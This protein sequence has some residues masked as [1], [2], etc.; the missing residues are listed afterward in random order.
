MTQISL[1]SDLIEITAEIN[2]F[3]Q[4]AGQAVIEIGKRLKHVRDNDLV[5]G[6]WEAWL[7]SLDIVPRTAQRM[8]Q[9]FEQFGKATTSSHL[10][11]GKIFEMLSLPE[12][13]DREEFTKQAHEIPSTGEQKTVDEMTVRE[14]REVKKAL[15]QVQKQAETAK[16]SANHFEHL[17]QQAKNQ[18]PKVITNSVEVVPETI[19]RELEDLKFQ[20][21]NL[22]AGYQEARQQLEKFELRDT[23]D[24]DEIEAQKQRK[25]LQHEADVN[26]LQIRSKINRFLE[27]A[28]I[29]TLMEGALS[30]A[31]P[32]TKQKIRES[33]EM[34]E[35]F[36]TQIKTALSGRIIGGVINE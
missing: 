22:R 15:Q 23:T 16:N 28:A 21:N 7:Q 10:S 30:A 6:Q 19:K 2:S 13:I 5:H 14:L 9:A 36:T 25:K 17:W 31:D 35:S 26:V 32:I 11:T 20:N 12:S 4:V 33:I 24:F 8:I 1:S 29:T 3:K 27:D 34:L 18:P